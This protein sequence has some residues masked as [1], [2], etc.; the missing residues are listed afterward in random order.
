MSWVAIID[1]TE[2]GVELVTPGAQRLEHE[3]GFSARA[4]AIEG[5]TSDRQGPFAAHPGHDDDDGDCDGDD[6][7][8]FDGDDE[9]GEG[10][11]YGDGDEEDDD[12]DD[13]EEDDDEPS[14]EEIEEAVNRARRI[15]RWTPAKAVDFLSSLEPS[16]A[17]SCAH[18]LLPLMVAKWKTPEAA[19][20]I[21][22][23]ADSD[24]VAYFSLL[25][26]RGREDLGTDIPFR[27]IFGP[28]D[29][30]KAATKLAD[31]LGMMRE[32]L[33]L[34]DD[35][36]GRT[37]RVAAATWA[38]DVTASEFAF[39]V[40]RVCAG[41]PAK[42]AAVL[43]KALIESAEG[44]GRQRQWPAWSDKWSQFVRVVA[45]AMA[46]PKRAKFAR[47]VAEQ[48]SWP[49]AVDA[50]SEAI[51]GGEAAEEDVA[52]S[53][54]SPGVPEIQKKRQK[55]SQPE[56]EPADGPAPAAAAAAPKKKKKKPTDAFGDDDDMDMNADD[57]SAF[58]DLL[59]HM[60][61]MGMGMPGFKAHRGGRR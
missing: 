8:M 49:G 19:E 60:A 42:R 35:E 16:V 32:E 44:S 10:G 52:D 31:C 34:D 15:T 61:G 17:S 55:K 28:G 22:E 26:A 29:D 43:L 50:L 1:V 33:G 25:D 20:F 54:A 12:E 46:Q 11:F 56:D 14:Q 38:V 30:E 41:I 36:F 13:D 48:W 45:E 27:S 9:D 6:D 21:W 5:E 3:D 47:S 53:T 39:T 24:A 2:A 59:Q 40:A 4:A 57:M 37:L 51:L 18:R 23:M 7:D 58:S